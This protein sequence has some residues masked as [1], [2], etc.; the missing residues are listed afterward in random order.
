MGDIMSR[1]EEAR[2][3]FKQD[4]F[5]TDTTGIVIEEVADGYSR[6][7]LNITEKH[8]AA[9][10]QV[11][12]GA[13]F[14]LADFAFAVA[15]NTK[16]CYTVTTTSNI[17]YVSMPKDNWLFAE[18]NTLKNGRRACYC[19]IKVTDGNGNLAAI[20]TTSGMHISAS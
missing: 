11:M 12:G 5:A 1:L 9:N 2:Q 6:C 19:E 18:C 17:C 10:N 8:L 3:F 16:D 4:R 13:I 15:T 7:S 14:T 20:V